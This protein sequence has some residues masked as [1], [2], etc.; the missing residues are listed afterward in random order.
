MG[1]VLPERRPAINEVARN[2]TAVTLT[3]V[4]R[5]VEAATSVLDLATR[6]GSVC[7]KNGRWI[8]EALLDKTAKRET[9]R[10]EK[11]VAAA[12]PSLWR[13]AV[14]MPE[15]MQTVMDDELVAFANHMQVHHPLDYLGVLRG[16]C[17]KALP[18][19]YLATE[20]E[21]TLDE[22]TPV[23]FA[24]RPVNDLFKPGKATPYQKTFA[25]T[26]L[27]K[28]L[29]FW[30]FDHSANGEIR[31]VLDYSNRSRIDEITWTHSSRL[32]QISTVHPADGDEVDIGFESEGEFFDI[33]PAR[34][35][36][37][38]VRYLLGSSP[39]SQIA[40]LP[41]LS[42]PSVD[43]LEQVLAEDH[44]SYPPL[45]VAGSAHVRLPRA[46]GGETR[47][48]ESRIYLDGKCVASHRKCFPFEAKKLAGKE[49]DQPLREALT[50]E[51]KTITVLSGTHTRLAVVICADLHN[52]PIPSMLTS[53]GVNL[54][55]APSMTPDPGGFNG[56]VCGVASQCQGVAAIANA[57]I[58]AAAMGGEPP[59]FLLMAAVPRPRAGD[60]SAEFFAQGEKS[61]GTVLVFDP[62]RRLGDE[63]AISWL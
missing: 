33:R 30:L 32:P 51:P 15:G 36:L 1:A 10:L 26:N 56:A 2:T 60:Q 21:I 37:D 22:G 40:V 62:N 34:W 53:A 6:L 31:V 57:Q 16:L 7:L 44:E 3:P 45:V 59:P 9:V 28:N 19:L 12:V 42:L 41:E 17:V 61:Q 55:L 20:D 29:G 11:M 43:A 46:S 58:D 54:L 24:T 38:E 8:R 47:A 25:K 5:Q 50:E 48:N 63:K 18:E 52:P 39:D 35:D 49:L 13:A 23:R 27:L 4:V 14:G